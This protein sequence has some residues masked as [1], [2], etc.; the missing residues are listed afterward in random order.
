MFLRCRV[1]M[2]RRGCQARRQEGVQT[3]LPVAAVQA[4]WQHQLLEECAQAVAEMR[5]LAAK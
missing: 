3:L 5:Q 2:T 1:V 4:T